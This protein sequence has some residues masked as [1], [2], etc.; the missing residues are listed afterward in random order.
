MT[1]KIELSG[2]QES[3][4]KA[5]ALAEGLSAEQ[6]A[7]RILEQELK[8]VKARPHISEIIVENMRDMPQDVLSAL[9]KDGASQHDHYI[10]G[11]P[12]RDQ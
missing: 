7:R 6:Y 1:L 3:A 8:A 4:L 5:K 10:Y 11:L 2:E 12:K 9:P